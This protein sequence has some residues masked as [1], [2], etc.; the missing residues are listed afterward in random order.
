MGVDANRGGGVRVGAGEPCNIKAASLPVALPWN[1]TAS[2]S[3]EGIDVLTKSLNILR[4]LEF[5]E[6]LYLTLCF[7]VVFCVVDN[8]LAVLLIAVD[9][10]CFHLAGLLTLTTLFVYQ[11]H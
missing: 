7:G 10:I 9:L 2:C 8:F 6:K 5:T 1:A 4:V 11:L 3:F